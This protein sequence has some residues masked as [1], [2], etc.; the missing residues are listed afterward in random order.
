M[1]PLKKTGNN[2]NFNLNYRRWLMRILSATLKSL[3]N[4]EDDPEDNA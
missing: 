3:G 2:S 1:L 4:D